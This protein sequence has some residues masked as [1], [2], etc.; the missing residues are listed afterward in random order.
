[1]F[2][3][4][5]LFVPARGG[6]SSVHT[7][8]D[9]DGGACSSSS[10]GY[11]LQGRRPNDRTAQEPT[12]PRGI[13]ALPVIEEWIETPIIDDYGVDRGTTGGWI[14]RPDLMGIHLRFMTQIEDQETTILV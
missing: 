4:P 7:G 5:W 9:L 14:R 8:R 6:Y 2:E 3:R 13:F 10:N 12:M 1:M 11:N